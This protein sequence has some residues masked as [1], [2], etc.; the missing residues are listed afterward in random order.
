[1]SQDIIGSIFIALRDHILDDQ[2]AVAVLEG[3]VQMSQLSM[4]IALLSS[5]DLDNL[6]AVLRRL[7]AALVDSPSLMERFVLVKD[8][9]ALR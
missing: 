8:K 5:E 7:D 3:F 6:R 9:L 1:M 2:E 4:T